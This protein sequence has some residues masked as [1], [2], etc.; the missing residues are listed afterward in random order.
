MANILKGKPV[1][2]LIDQKTKEIISGKQ[3]TLATIRVSDNKDDIEI[4][5]KWEIKAET[6]KFYRSA[7]KNWTITDPLKRKTA[8]D[9]KLNYLEIFPNDL[10]KDG[11]VFLINISHN[12]TNDAITRIKVISFIYSI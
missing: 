10:Y 6:S 11:L 1:S 9:N 2:L 8:K 4:L 5:N 7:I 12:C 3:V